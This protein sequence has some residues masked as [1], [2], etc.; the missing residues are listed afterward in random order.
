MSTDEL[1]ALPQHGAAEGTR[2]DVHNPSVDVHVAEAGMC[3][4]VHLPSARI[5]VLSSRHSG[6]CRFVPRSLPSSPGN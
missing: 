3:G 2:A 1:S 6:P 5:C 4:N